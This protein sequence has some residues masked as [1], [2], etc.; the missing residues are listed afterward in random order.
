MAI[1]AIG[2]IHGCYQNLVLLITSIPRSEN[3]TFIF[4]GDYVDRGEDTKEVIAFFIEFSK[5]N[6]CVF[7]KGNHEIFMLSA[8]IDE[9]YFSDWL[10]FGGSEVLKSYQ[11]DKNDLNWE[12]KIPES[13]W[14]FLASTLPY[15]E[16]DSYIFVHAGL[17]KGVS[18]INQNK[19]YLYWEKFI[20]PEQYSE[21]KIVVCGHTSRKNGLIAN[22]GH[23]ICIDTFAYGGKWLTALNVQ[24]GEF[25]QSNLEN[26][27]NTGFI[28]IG[29]NE[30]E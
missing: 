27:I 25:Y 28:Q 12:S 29:K 4:L 21:D 19:H 14:K 1:W 7:L 9:H 16:T 10:C 22:F 20:I 13:H 17:E 3:D 11:I 2:D 6:N 23:S 30:F 5:L 15:Y 26:E 24:S 18:L 8:T